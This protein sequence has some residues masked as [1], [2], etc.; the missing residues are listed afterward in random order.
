MLDG[1]SEEHLQ[2]QIQLIRL[3]F[4]A[5]RWNK[6]EIEDLSGVRYQSTLQTSDSNNKLIRSLIDSAIVDDAFVGWPQLNYEEHQAFTGG[7]SGISFYNGTIGVA[8]VL[9]HWD[10][11]FQCHDSRDM[12]KRIINHAM[13]LSKA[14]SALGFGL[15]G[16]AGM[17]YAAHHIAQCGYPEAKK[18]VQ[19]IVQC[20]G[21]TPIEHDE[22]FDVM[23]GVSHDITT[24]L[25]FADIYSIDD[26]V[27]HQCMAH[28]KDKCPDP[29]RFAHDEESFFDDGSP[30]PP[31][32]G[33]AHG[34]AG[35]AVAFSRYAKRYQDNES[36][37]WV[38][39]TMDLLD[40][41]FH[42]ECGYWPDMRLVKEC[43]SLT[44]VTA[45]PPSWCGGH[46]GI[47]LFYLECYLHWP[48]LKQR[49]QQ[50]LE[51]CV[52]IM[53]KS[54]DN[55]QHMPNLCCGFYGDLDLLLLIDQR[56]SDIAFD[57]LKE[58]IDKL[59]G[60]SQETSLDTFFAGL[61]HGIPSYLYL[62]LRHQFPESM[63]SALYW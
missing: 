40:E 37:A 58:T 44:E 60:I 41:H 31:K 7:L 21:K 20:A 19:H 33:Y 32:L 42:H 3:S 39:Q 8:F 35:V 6:L 47:A 38:I 63:P 2:N 18:L 45:A 56:V 61:F 36:E 46:A 15:A 62:N 10:R 1:L 16:C 49:A 55:E 51:R 50:G 52:A 5:Y 25:H 29:A 30:H 24:L 12:V 48:A 53:V 9:A 4:K 26:Q 23:S 54:S 43:C 57:G 13:D 17:L 34:L 11:Y 14:N 28:L 27:I 59:H 22:A